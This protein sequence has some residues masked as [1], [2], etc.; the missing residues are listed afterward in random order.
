FRRA[1]TELDL[2]LGALVLDVGCGT[3]RALPSLRAAIGPGGR[4]LGL[5]ATPQMLAEATRLGRRTVACLALADVFHLP[6]PDASLDAV[7]AGGLIPHLHDA[8]V[9]LAELA[10]VVRAGGRLAVFHP[11][12][13]AALAAR[14]GGAPSD[15]DAIAPARLTRS[16]TTAGWLVDSIDD[17]ADRFLALATRTS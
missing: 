9:G 13:R 17:A 16:L 12:S 15:D 10:R 6:L 14:H 7:F 3:G 4:L 2:P 1:V 11:L 8:V 5:D